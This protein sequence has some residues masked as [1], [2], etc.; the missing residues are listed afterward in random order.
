MG[1]FRGE[2]GRIVGICNKVLVGCLSFDSWLQLQNTFCRQHQ[3][4]VYRITQVLE[5]APLELRRLWTVIEFTKAETVNNSFNHW[6]K[7]NSWRDA[8][9]CE[10]MYIIT[11][12]YLHL[13]FS[14]KSFKSVMDNSLFDLISIRLQR[15]WRQFSREHYIFSEFFANYMLIWVFNMCNP[16]YPPVGGAGWGNKLELAISNMFI[17]LLK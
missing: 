15:I 2:N 10:S 4:R 7:F 8:F 1:K 5:D 16:W 9:Y 12:F 6:T 14:N 17:L 3:L 13:C 11:S